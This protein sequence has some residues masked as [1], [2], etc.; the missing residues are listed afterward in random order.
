VHA[1]WG[2]QVIRLAVL[3]VALSQAPTTSGLNLN[4]QPIDGRQNGARL[5]KWRQ[6]AIDCRTNM[7]CTV[8]GGVL[9]L[10]ASGGGGGGPAGPAAP[11]DGG[12]VVWTSVGSTNERVLSGGVSTSIDTSTPGQIRVDVVSPVAS[13]TTATTAT[14]ATTATA[15][16]ANPTDCAAGQ[17][18]TTIAANGDLTCAQ[19]ATSQLSGSVNLATQVTGNLPVTNLA[20][21]TGASATTFWRG[22]GTW[23][24]PSGGGG[25]GWAPD[26]GSLRLVTTTGYTGTGTGTTSVPMPALYYDAGVVG[27]NFTYRCR[28]LTAVDGGTG[29][30]IRVTTDFLGMTAT[31]VRTSSMRY[32]SSATAGAVIGGSLTATTVN[33]APTASQGDT[34]CEYEFV[35]HVRNVTAVGQVRVFLYSELAAPNRVTALPGSYCLVDHW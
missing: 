8:D 4:T 12:F 30:G 3:A 16:A 24:T 9:T 28:L 31:E 22:D 32:C 33:F 15:L 1:Q 6:W 19:V 5:S 29:T 2:A 34:P 21:G 20:G 17:Y 26:G 10:N 13:A 11:V 23:A 25:G 35:R 14:S 27:A 18:A 7:T